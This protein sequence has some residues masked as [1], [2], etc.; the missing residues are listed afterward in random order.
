MKLFFKVVSKSICLVLFAV[1]SLLTGRCWGAAEHSRSRFV[2]LNLSATDTGAGMTP[3]GEMSFSGNNLNWSPPE[4]YSEVKANWDLASYGGT[5]EDGVKYIYAKYKDT[6]DNWSMVEISKSVILDTKTPNTSAAPIGGAYSQE[7]TVV[8]GADEEAAIYFTADGTAPTLASPIYAQPISVSTT[9]VLQF[10][11]VDPAGN[12]EEV[13]REEYIIDLTPP[14]VN[15]MSPTPNEEGVFPNA[16]IYVSLTDKESGMDL[17]S[18]ILKIDGTEVTPEVSGAPAS[19]A[20]TYY[21]SGGWGYNRAVQVNIIARDRVTPPHIL[22][23]SYHFTTQSRIREAE[24]L[25]INIGGNEYQDTDGDTWLMDQSYGQGNN[26]GYIGGIAVSFSA[27][28]NNTADDPLYQDQRHGLQEYIFDVSNGNYLVIFHFAEITFEE[29][30][31]RVF[32]ITMEDKVIVRNLDIYRRFGRDYAADIGLITSVSDG[33][34]NLEFTPKQDL[35][36]MAAIEIVPLEELASPDL[37]P[38][39]ATYLTPAPEATNI[40]VDTPISVMLLDEESGVDLFSIKFTLNNSYKVSPTQIT[41]TP[42]AY[43]LS[44]FL[45]SLKRYPEEITVTV[46]ADDLAGNSMAPVSWTY[47]LGLYDLLP[48]DA[49]AE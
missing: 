38:P 24:W 19:Y 22:D 12:M 10:F 4:P 15:S 46:N 43:Q 3:D 27:E 48:S 32:G 21:P 11:A 9:T 6:V 36:Q 20:I 37:T 1:F 31:M 41:G 30:R 44:C 2:T 17:S 14:V 13:K 28:I 33:R 29:P 8:L 7:Q 26:W 49:Q 45:P 34:L 39:E 35:P 25:R 47:T 18:I 23:Y 16:G 5:P 40:T 42:F